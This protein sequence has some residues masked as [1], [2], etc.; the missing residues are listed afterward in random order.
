MSFKTVL[1]ALV[2]VGFTAPAAFA[3]EVYT[4]KLA[5]PLVEQKLGVRADN[6]RWNC[7]GDTCLARG[8]ERL[9]VRGCQ[10]LVDRTGAKVVSYS[11]P[12]KTF[13]AEELERCNGVSVSAD[14]K[15]SESASN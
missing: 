5:T 11:T 7:S 2:F 14:E 8:S 3:S 1:A 9:S 13:S 6:V 10:Q 4:A 12:R 15:P